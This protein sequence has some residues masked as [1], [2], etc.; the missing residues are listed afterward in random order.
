MYYYKITAVTT[1]GESV[2]SAEVSAILGGGD[3]LIGNYY[4]GTDLSGTA[5]QRVDPQV[6]FDWKY[7]HTD[8][9]DS[10]RYVFR[11]LDGQ[12]STR[13]N[14]Q[15]HVLYHQRRRRAIIYQWKT[16]DQQLDATWSH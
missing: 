9:G 3:G 4:K 1:G 5:I 8:V 6:N 13:R 16:G 11:R 14:Q 12:H 7:G 15:L 2:A 10:R